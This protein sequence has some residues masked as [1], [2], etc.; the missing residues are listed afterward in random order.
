[1]TE[2]YAHNTEAKS[3]L[4]DPLFCTAVIGILVQ[5]LGGTA[6]LTQA[7][8]DA[9]FRRQLLEHYEPLNSSL[10]LVVRERPP[11]DS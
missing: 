10:T 6:T 9:I 8:F 11:L 2:L 1:M 4:A 3:P 5:R 7:D